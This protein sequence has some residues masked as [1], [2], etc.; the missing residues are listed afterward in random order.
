MSLVEQWAESIRPVCQAVDAHVNL[1]IE[2]AVDLGTQLAAAR[3]N[4]GY[5]QWRRMFRS[6]P[7]QIANPLPITLQWARAMIRI[8]ANE[9][10]RDLAPELPA[11]LS[12]LAAL[13]TIEPDRLRRQVRTGR[14]NRHTTAARAIALARA[15]KAKKHAGHVDDEVVVRRLVDHV[16]QALRRIRQNRPHLLGHAQ[17]TLLAAVRGFAV[18]RDGDRQ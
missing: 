10:L 2:A 3:T 8:A 18:A 1:A 12:A 9:A 16:E 15:G 7:D 6:Q 4:L 17:R 5:A 13:A 11:T 14:V